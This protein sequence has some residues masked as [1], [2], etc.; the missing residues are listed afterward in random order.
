MTLPE[1]EAMV[2]LIS[3]DRVK[4][5]FKSESWRGADKWKAHMYRPINV[6]LA[7]EVQ[8]WTLLNGWNATGP[9]YAKAFDDAVE[10]ALQWADNRAKLKARARGKTQ[11]EIM[12]G[13][14]R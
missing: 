10:K 12:K 5:E 3:G 14:L 4:F 11:R 9:T 13:I 1:L 8:V 7:E 2:A 6:G